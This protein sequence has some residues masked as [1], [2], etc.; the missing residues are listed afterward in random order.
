MDDPD[1]QYGVRSAWK[2]VDRVIAEREI[3]AAEGDEQDGSNKQKQK[4]SKA[5][6]QKRKQDEG[7]HQPDEA[8]GDSKPRQ[9]KFLVKWRELQYDACTWESEA[10]LAAWGAD[11]EIARFR[12]LDPIQSSAEARK[13]SFGRGLSRPQTTTSVELL[14]LH[15]HRSC[16]FSSFHRRWCCVV[17]ARG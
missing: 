8:A 3:S 6:G 17:L 13:V 5:D 15:V 2:V 9:R 16:C 10:D 12:A 11:A 4:Q 1:A 14:S 7:N